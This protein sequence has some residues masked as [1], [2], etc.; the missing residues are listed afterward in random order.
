[1]E[2]MSVA[3]LLLFNLVG[4]SGIESS[5]NLTS[6]ADK[7]G[8]GAET[9][10]ALVSGMLILVRG[11]AE[12]GKT[13]EYKL[14]QL[15]EQVV[16]Q[17]LKQNVFSASPAGDALTMAKWT[18]FCHVWRLLSGEKG[19]RCQDYWVAR[20]RRL[21]LCDLFLKIAQLELLRNRSGLRL[22]Y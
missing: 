5:H 19:F 7:R 15:T 6:G 22:Y 13:R 20:T 2:K 16:S 18:G 8:L 14:E 11:N 1:M 9:H 4:V 17:L 10:A 12:S 21:P 3:Q